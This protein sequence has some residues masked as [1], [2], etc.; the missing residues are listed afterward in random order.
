L[1]RTFFEN[2]ALTRVSDDVEVQ[3]AVFEAGVLRLTLVRRPD[4]FG[5]SHVLIGRMRDRG[6]WVLRC[7][8]R[9]V[10]RG[11]GLAINESPTLDITAEPDG[12]A[13]RCPVGVHELEMRFV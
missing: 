4:T 5:N 2:P 7:D 9:D 10:A 12:L 3:R 13:L 1:D 11:T 8:A 6:S